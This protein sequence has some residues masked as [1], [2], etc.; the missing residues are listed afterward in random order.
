MQDPLGNF[1]RIR[2]YYLSYL[3]TAFRIRDDSVTKERRN[4]LSEPGQLCA[5]PYIE[6]VPR[7]VNAKDTFEE[8]LNNNST[9]NPLHDLA[10]STR[11]VFLE[12][13]LSGLFDSG[14]VGQGYEGQLT[15]K[16]KYSPY[17]HQLE[18]LK[19]GVKEGSPGIVTSGTGSGKTEAFLMPILAKIVE[20]AIGHWDR[21]SDGYLDNKWWRGNGDY[22]LHR[23]G[24]NRESAVRALILYPMNALVD[25]QAVRLRKSLDS[26]EARATLEEHLNGNRIFFGRYTGNTSPTGYSHSGRMEGIEDDGS[27]YCGLDT[28]SFKKDENGHVSYKDIK[29]R[30]LDRKKTKC[31]DL[32]T[33]LQEIEKAQQD[34][35]LFAISKKSESSFRKLIYGMDL[36]L[37]TD[38]FWEK[39]SEVG[40]LLEGHLAEIYT[41]VCLNRNQDVAD[42]VVTEDFFADADRHGKVLELSENTSA[43][44]S[45]G[46]EA[47]FLEASLDGGELV[48]RWDIQNT[49]PDIL[50]TNSS[51]L[52]VM[53]NREVDSPIFE[54]TKEWLKKDDSYFYLV[55]DELHLY[56][57]TAGTEVAYLLRLL[58]HRLGLV[59]TPEQR[60]KVR[61]LASSASLPDRPR[62]AAGESAQFLWD[63][64]E[65]YG[66]GL[67]SEDEF[68]KDKWLESIVSGS[69]E[70]ANPVNSVTLDPDLFNNLYK[71]YQQRDGVSFATPSKPCS[72]KELR[73]KAIAENIDLPS[74]VELPKLLTSISQAIGDRINLACTKSVDGEKQV[75]STSL[76]DIADLIFPSL[77]ESCY[78]EKY[79]AVKSLLFARGATD[80]H[81]E[82][83]NEGNIAGTSFRVHTFFKGIE[84]LFAPL[85]KNY[86][87]SL[88]DEDDS[89]ERHVNIG[90]LSLNKA[91]KEIDERYERF[92][93]LPRFELLYCECCGE[94]LI[95]GRKGHSPRGQLGELI[96]HEPELDKLPSNHANRDFTGFSFKEY[97]VFWPCENSGQSEG[98]GKT[99][100]KW[101]EGYLDVVTGSV[102]AERDERKESLA[103]YYFHYDRGRDKHKR[104][105]SVSGTHTPHTCPK[106]ETSYEG[107]KKDQNLSPIRNF[108]IGF[109]KTTQILASELFDTL[110]V[111]KSND[112]KLISF[113]DS[114]QGAASAALD[115]EQGHYRDFRRASIIACLREV[116]EEKQKTIKES[117]Q[118]LEAIVNEMS[119]LNPGSRA[120]DLLRQEETSVNER[121]LSASETSIEL[122]EI[123]EFDGFTAGDFTKSLMRTYHDFGIHPFDE[124]GK[125]L[126]KGRDTTWFHWWK[127]LSMGQGPSSWAHAEGNIS[128]EDTDDFF[129]KIALGIPDALIHKNYFS[130]EEAG[131]GYLT[132]PLRKLP[133]SRRSI[134]RV[135]ELSALIRVMTDNY[136]YEPNVWDNEVISDHSVKPKNKRVREYIKHLNVD[137]DWYIKAR[138]DLRLNGDGHFEWK[139]NV[140]NLSVELVDE[141]KAFRCDKCDRV[142]WHKGS[143]ICTRCFSDVS[144]IKPT[145][146]QDHFEQRSFLCRKVQRAVTKSGLNNSFRLHTEE[147]TGQS[148]ESPSRQRKFKGV[149]VPTASFANSDSAVDVYK[150]WLAEKARDEIDLLSVTTTMEVG[151]DI[152]PLECIFQA[153]MPP[154][155]FN[156]QQRV[157][158]AGRRGQAFSLALTLC[159]SKNHDSYYFSRPGSIT[160][161]TPPIPFLAKNNEKIALRILYKGWFTA[162]FNLMRDEMREDGEVYPAELLYKGDTH[163][164]YL[165]TFCLTSH[166]KEIF[167]ERMKRCL[168]NTKNI[169]AEI[170]ACLNRT[171]NL[172]IGINV[173]KVIDLIEIAI[174]ESPKD[175]LA[176]T[177]AEKGMLPMYGMPTR[178]RDFYL[179]VKSDG[180]WR[181]ASRDLE[182][183]IFEYAPGEALTLDKKVYWSVGLTPSIPKVNHWIRDHE[184]LKTFEDK[185]FSEAFY[186]TECGFCSCYIKTKAVDESIPDLCPSCKNSIDITK[187]TLAIVP[188]GFMATSRSI[189]PNTQSRSSYGQGLEAGAASLEFDEMTDGNGKAIKFAQPEESIT[190]R[191]NRGPRGEN[192]DDYSFM[193]QPANKKMDRVWIEAARRQKKFQVPHQLKEIKSL[194]T[195]SSL[196]NVFGNYPDYDVSEEGGLLNPS[197]N[198]E[199]MWLAA[200]KVTD[201]MYLMPKS[202]SEGLALKRMIPGARPASP[203]DSNWLAVRAAAI[204]ASHLLAQQA[205][206]HFDIDQEE[207][208]ILEPKMH[209]TGGPRMPLL[210]I[211]DALINGSGFVKELCSSEKSPPLLMK[212][213]N[214]IVNADSDSMSRLLDECHIR[215]CTSSCYDCLQTYRNEAFHPLLDWRLGI[216]FLRSLTDAN[217]TCG[218]DSDFNFIGLRDWP[219]AAKKAASEFKERYNGKIKELVGGDMTAVSIPLGGERWSKW[220]IVRHPLWDWSDAD[221]NPI[222]DS[223]LNKAAKEMSAAG[224]EFTSWDSFNLSKRQSDI[225]EWLKQ[226]RI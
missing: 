136:R 103:G 107:R 76:R 65:Q 120:M 201:S 55:L 6:P 93:S 222:E 70:E 110:N 88:L 206:I 154:Q 25:D 220:I 94:L 53:L 26:R 203:T 40:K 24:E 133:E 38:I 123:I 23:R 39:M 188:G 200:P 12:L 43:A 219:E 180:Q 7:Y 28:P 47:P 68:H 15:R 152:G 8:L 30:Q 5:E 54:K 58:L 183:A 139:I 158:R 36:P 150:E 170:A 27:I 166:Q 207:F 73:W 17:L 96:Q 16:E 35:R 117:K 34:A 91:S 181:K 95:G 175:G 140:R 64:F 126:V 182:S 157:G 195:L 84:G 130:I 99:G 9:A 145:L 129:S 212:I 60:A 211:T 159:R 176:E 223:I 209:S 149:F 37:T 131:L 135:Q 118:E 113:S 18:M 10:P 198:P 66:W 112:S 71:E 75:T 190:Y 144:S 187:K 132:V 185:A 214:T 106:C 77:K 105:E 186:L 20:E 156:Y 178:S 189:P 202:F 74:D 127:L 165:P 161:D 85:V 49:P 147:L 162:A 79:E 155:R 151:I 13:V 167:W 42:T 184:S 89:D 174:Q 134:K 196:K 119:G 205:S 32:K 226:G 141:Q 19:R 87:N 56:R 72:Q 48:N 225:R 115:I 137:E 171:I 138:E 57:G 67:T 22:Q 80:G 172:D 224:L 33:H 143:G 221:W 100:I 125:E 63:M 62:E 108:R 163:G 98:L 213:I 109:A 104:K 4:L 1:E 128:I 210:Q 169:A 45:C 193:F 148:D 90:K 46:I 177:L 51:M 41:E 164:E 208:D 29:E 50:I 194:E 122:K 81:S 160:G 44:S 52:S 59:E 204:T 11:K 116:K 111:D 83:F 114:R 3:D 124:V 192:A 82:L 191:V 97:G 21:P 179:E 168:E 31:D 61:I 218:L 216:L 197:G 86:G 78:E 173:S 153:N 2:D 102:T 199:P 215:K 14:P 69:E 217:F 146:T 101:K 142:H 92:D 121:I